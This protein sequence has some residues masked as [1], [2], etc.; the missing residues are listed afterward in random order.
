MSEPEARPVSGHGFEFLDDPTL[1]VTP[2]GKICECNRSART[3]FGTNYEYGTL[4]DFVVEPPENWVRYLRLASGSTAP[5]PGKFTF[6]RVTGLEPLRTQAARLSRGRSETEVV[7]R[8]LPQTSDRFAFLDQRVRELDRQLQKRHQENAALQDA[9]QKNRALLG[10]LQ[11]RVKNNIQLM[12]SLINRAGERNRTPEVEAVV[13]VSRGRLQAMAAAQ[14][15][16]YQADAAEFVAARPFFEGVVRKVARN[17][18]AVHAVSMALIDG[19]LNSEEAY[20]LALIANELISNAAKH[21]LR[22]GAGSISVAFA[23]HGDHYK[24]E[25]AD[26]GPGMSAAAASRSS[27][28][29]L[30][31]GLCRQIGGQLEIDGGHGTRCSIVFPREETRKAL[32]GDA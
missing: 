12:I 11:H 14:E 31:R 2:S 16:L 24:F 23:E 8:L 29:A 6:R 26:D 7:I 15:A 28:L 4:G 10:E 13:S 32:N 30:V 9:L 18:D 21:G 17:N 22:N 5:R 25:V 27:G 19:K 1:V 3:Y 20:C